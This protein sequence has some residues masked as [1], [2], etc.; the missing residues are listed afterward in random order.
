[1]SRLTTPEKVSLTFAY[2]SA[3]LAASESAV[4]IFFAARSVFGARK[5]ARSR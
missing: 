3:A 1:M 5:S 2:A 4:F